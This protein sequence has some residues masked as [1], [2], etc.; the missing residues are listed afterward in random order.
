MTYDPLLAGFGTV[1]H[2]VDPAFY[3]RLRPGYLTDAILGH[4]ARW[5]AGR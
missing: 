3:E 5:H 2:H 4:D 1:V